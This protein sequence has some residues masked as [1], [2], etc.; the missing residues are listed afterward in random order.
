MGVNPGRLKNRVTVLHGAPTNTPAGTDT[1]WTVVNT[2]W[3]GVTQVSA[4]GTARYQQAG[5]SEVTHE[6]LLRA[7]PTFTLGTTL[8]RHADLTLQPAAPPI[9]KGHL[10]TI[11]CRVI[12]AVSTGEEGYGSS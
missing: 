2:L 11:P 12:P 4:S 8:F 6:V 9:T 7:G 3:A 1:V 5:Y 10:I